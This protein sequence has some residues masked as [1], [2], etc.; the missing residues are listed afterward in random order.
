MG[1]SE[2]CTHEME[3]MP[4]PEYP[5]RELGVPIV[6]FNSVARNVCKHCGEVTHTIQHPERLVAAAAVG[7]CK[8]DD[9]LSGSEI[10]FLRKAMG[11][12]SKALAES[13]NVTPETFSR[14]ENDKAPI[15]PGAEKML[16]LSVC[17]RLGSSAPAIDFKPG[18][19]L[20]MSIKAIRTEEVWMAL[21]LVRFKATDCGSTDAYTESQRKVA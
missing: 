10:R 16:R 14:W 7:R 2:T 9:K 4:V 18:E 12:P 17:I 20:D 21:E 13:L 6:I 8:I 5:T 3:S 11:M 1:S 15:S 19:I